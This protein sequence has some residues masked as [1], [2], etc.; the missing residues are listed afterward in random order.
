MHAAQASQPSATAN[1]GVKLLSNQEVHGNALCDALGLYSGQ[2]DCLESVCEDVRHVFQ[3]MTPA[4]SSPQ[5]DECSKTSA[6][7]LVEGSMI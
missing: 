3:A 2:D 4:A 1:G 6:Q 5:A 7:K